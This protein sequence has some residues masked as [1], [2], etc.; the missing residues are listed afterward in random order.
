[1]SA[2]GRNNNNNNGGG[3]NGGPNSNIGG[4]AGFASY[5]VGDSVRVTVRGGDVREKS[6]HVIVHTGD[7][8]YAGTDANVFLTLFGS[9]GQSTKIPLNNS[10]NK[11]SPFERGQVDEFEIRARDVGILYRVEVC[12]DNT[13][14][15]PGWFLNQ[16]IIREKIEDGSLKRSVFPLYDWLFKENSADNSGLT[17]NL[18][19]DGIPIVTMEAFPE[20]AVEHHTDKFK[21]IEEDAIL[22]RRGQTFKMTVVL[23]RKYHGGTD[24]FHF[25][26]KT[27]KNARSINKTL[28]T[29]EECT[30]KEF[31]QR[32]QQDKW[33]YRIV[34]FTK[35][36]VNV[37]IF[38]PSDA[39]VGCFS[40]TL[41]D[42][43]GVIY[44][45]DSKCCIL[46]NPWC[47]DDEVYMEDEDKIK[48]YLLRQRGLIY[49][50][51]GYRPV[52]LK[53]YFGQFEEICL[54]TV[55]KML[56]EMKGKERTSAALIARFL[57]SKGNSCDNTGLLS[58]RWDGNYDDGKAPTSWSST[59]D[60]LQ[61]YQQKN[62]SVKYGQCWVFS[63]MLTTVFRAIGIPCRPVT[64]YSSAH[65]SDGNC[66]NDV[67]FDKEGEPL[68]DKSSDSVW[69]FHVWNDVWMARPDLPPGYGG[70]QA[71][72]STPQER[73]MGLYQM[74]P[75]SLLA[76]KE[77]EIHLNYDTGFVFAEVNADTIY[78]QQNDDGKF[79]PVYRSRT[80]I[81]EK[82]VTKAVGEDKADDITDE[83][84]FVEGSMMERASVKKALLKSKNIA[85]KAVPKEIVVEISTEQEA[86]KPGSDL[87]GE[88]KIENTCGELR[89]MTLFWRVFVVRYDGVV[90]KVVKSD[91][92]KITVKGNTKH[93]NFFE[94]NTKEVEDYLSEETLFRITGTVT[95]DTTKQ[96]AVAS[97]L[98]N[99][100]KPELML[101]ILTPDVKAGKPMQCELSMTNPLSKILTECEVK[102]D[103]SVIEDRH[104][105]EVSDVKEGSTFKKIVEITPDNI[106]EKSKKKSLMASFYSRQL[107]GIQQTIGIKVMRL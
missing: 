62:L 82:V 17:K 7:I 59:P 73:S 100:D 83:Y 51:T 34:D 52:P 22:L 77:G 63:A 79:D 2:S 16:I 88:I 25:V 53:W 9:K 15:F 96:L 48:E 42:D 18:E 39:L 80:T 87:T 44:L 10:N 26:L 28:V 95:V 38:I 57:S 81:G 71:V 37:E 3:V 55:L 23:A 72:D 27:G 56:D 21:L 103:G 19:L 45:H 30:G 54:F 43:D 46:F 49:R 76:I 65:D 89:T 70:W 13:G 101:K 6:Y 75:C 68:D 14:I 58:G 104:V 85:V 11:K 92:H 107:G 64:N 40:L 105:E 90:I 1:M 67:Y 74:G 5:R 61:H 29:I 36:E 91:K 4:V 32:K 41:E 33:G 99:I 20:T 94:I 12:H 86:F 66:S 102:I 35:T 47:K 50:G 24:D 98:V 97:H 93:S 78:W 60:I 106:A 8:K 84:K 31:V 69:N